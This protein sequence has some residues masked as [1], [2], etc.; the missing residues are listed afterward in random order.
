VELLTHEEVKSALACP[1]VVRAP[2]QPLVCEHGRY[3]RTVENG[4]ATCVCKDC[5]HR[6][7]EYPLTFRRR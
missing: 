6:W 4:R 2:A 7:N 5:K 3:V 1:V